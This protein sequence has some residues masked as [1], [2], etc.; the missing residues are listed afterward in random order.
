M[1]EPFIEYVQQLGA[2][3]SD[4]P[5]KT[6]QRTD[7]KPADMTQHRP[8]RLAAS[9]AIAEKKLHSSPAFEDLTLMI[10]P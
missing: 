4:R 10:L 5:L 7:E 8:G 2:Y 1:R 6:M 9:T 3:L